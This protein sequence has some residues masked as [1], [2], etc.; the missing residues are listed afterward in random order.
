VSLSALITPGP[1]SLPNGYSPVK[2]YSNAQR[3]RLKIL[4]ENKNLIGIYMWT[5]LKNGK[6]Y[7]GSSVDISRRMRGYF[8]DK[9]LRFS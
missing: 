5:N 2:T 1:S 4:K 6:R 9:A 7:I 8:S 3:D